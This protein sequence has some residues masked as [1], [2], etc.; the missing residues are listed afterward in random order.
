MSP[1]SPSP[2]TQGGIQ[3]LGVDLL[4]RQPEQA[5][6]DSD[7]SGG[8]GGSGSGGRDQQS[9][10]GSTGGG[11]AGAGSKA[12]STVRRE[13][14]AIKAAEQGSEVLTTSNG[15]SASADAQAPSLGGTGELGRQRRR[16]QPPGQPLGQQR[17]HQGGGHGGPGRQVDK[18]T[19]V[20]DAQARLTVVQYPPRRP[21]AAAEGRD[22]GLGG[23]GGSGGGSADDNGDS[24]GSWGISY[25][26]E[27]EKAAWRGGRSGGA[28]GSGQVGVMR[29]AAGLQGQG[30]YALSGRRARSTRHGGV[31][32]GKGALDCCN[33]V[34]LRSQ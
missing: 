18:V 6:R 30:Q 29:G 3:S 14:R 12:G 27:G 20:T 26:E 7:E 22:Q 25:E 28:G 5:G 2:A 17:G 13:D 31:H 34:G 15:T 21:K 16:Q 23:G 8:R 24:D 19:V 33:A 11:G 32:R 10:L 1:T 4:Q 9:A